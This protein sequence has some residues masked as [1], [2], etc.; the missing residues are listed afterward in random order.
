MNK[1]GFMA[2]ITSSLV[3]AFII[4]IIFLIVGGSGGF[5]ALSGIG[6]L[7]G[8]IPVFVWLIFAAFILLNNLRGR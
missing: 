6:N 3:F 4:L 8:Q 5:K 2:Y 1:K 7:I